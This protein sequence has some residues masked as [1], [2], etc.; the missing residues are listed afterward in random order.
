MCVFVQRTTANVISGFVVQRP[1]TSF[2]LIYGTNYT[3]RFSLLKL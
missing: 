2:A 3:L 1:F